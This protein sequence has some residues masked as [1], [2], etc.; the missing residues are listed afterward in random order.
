MVAGCPKCNSRYR[1][2]VEKIGSEGAKLRCTK[3]S[4]V[5]LVRA[6]QAATEPPAPAPDPAPPSGQ[7]IDS[8]RTV[9]VADPEESR[10]RLVIELD[11]DRTA[12]EHWGRSVERA[13]GER[14]LEY[15]QKRKSG[16]LRAL[17]IISV[18][19]GTGELY[20]RHLL[21]KGQR[22]GQFKLVALQYAT[23]CTFDFTSVS[24]THASLD[25]P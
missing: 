25:S 20:K 4:A 11:L 19:S 24:P 16:R 6:P 15:A 23:D 18:A 9:L 2:D 3:C 8:K 13:L 21:A 5:F 14:N 10:Y 17:Q 22:E 12:A 1:V 7:K